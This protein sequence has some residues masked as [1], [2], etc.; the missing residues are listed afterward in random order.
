MKIIKRLTFVLP[1]LLCGMMT[2]A[3]SWDHIGNGIGQDAA[4]RIDVEV[5]N[6]ELYVSELMWTHPGTELRLKKWDGQTWTNLPTYTA[7]DDYEFGEMAMYQGEIYAGMI[8]RGPGTACLIKFDGTQWVSMPLPNVGDIWSVRRLEVH[9]GELYIGGSFDITIGGTTYENIVK[10]D[11]TNFTGLSGANTEVGDI[12]VSNGDLYC[13]SG[14][15]LKLTGTSFVLSAQLPTGGGWPRNFLTTYNNDLYCTV[16]TKL[17]RIDIGTATSTLLK[18]FPYKITDMDVMGGELYIVGDTLVSSYILG[19]GLE[20]F[21]GQNFTTLTA[22]DGLHSGTVFNSELHYFSGSVTMY[23]GAQY[24]RAFKMNSTLG[25]D[26]DFAKKAGFSVYPNPARNVFYIENS[27]NEE[28]N[29]QLIDATGRVIQNISLQPE[30]KAEVRT[31][32]LAP[33]MYF[34]NNGENTHRVIITH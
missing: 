27:V 10:F 6:N 21:D 3:Q 26:E 19:G 33:G 5:Y 22:P 15:L 20:K 13:I 11:G 7:P 9:N 24:D 12:H 14:A 32:S 16:N 8:R 28:Q 18:T 25:I 23:N 30:T 31:E 4:R 1:I 29:V 2:Q 34:I 17:Y